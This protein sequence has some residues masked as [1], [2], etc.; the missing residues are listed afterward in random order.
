MTSPA[1]SCNTEPKKAQ[2]IVR[3]DDEAL[4][5]CRTTTDY[6]AFIRLCQ[7]HGVTLLGAFGSVARGEAQ[8]ASDA[9]L[10]IQS[11]TQQLDEAQ[12]HHSKLYQD[13]I[14]RQLE[15]I[16]EAVKQLSDDLRQQYAQIPWR[17]LAMYIWHPLIP[18]TL[19][20]TALSC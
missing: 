19:E 9:C 12:F 11:Y 17:Y 18:I 20:D 7:Q 6:A 10:Q 13:A 5:S 8:A 16:G 4:R 15:I 1:V 2:R 14:V 3:C